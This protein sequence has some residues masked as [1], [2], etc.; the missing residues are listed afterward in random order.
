MLSIDIRD[1]IDTTHSDVTNDTTVDIGTI[2]ITF[3]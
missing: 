2:D 1:S 3:D